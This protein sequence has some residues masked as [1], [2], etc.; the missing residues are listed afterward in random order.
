MTETQIYW[1]ITLP[2]IGN[3]L[4]VGMVVIGIIGSLFIP[5]VYLMTL[6]SYSEIKFPKFWFGISIAIL[7]IGTILSTFIPTTK[8]LV[9]IYSIPRVINN[10]K[11][12]QI[13][14]KLLEYA[15]LKLDDLVKDAK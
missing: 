1:L 10:E 12:N 6:G 8:E 7:S 13:P 2:K 5:F 15:N 11:V 3:G 14:E 9:A 4:G